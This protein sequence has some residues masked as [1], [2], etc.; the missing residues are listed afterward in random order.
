MRISDPVQAADYDTALAAFGSAAG[1]GVAAVFHAVRA[2][3]YRSGKDRTPLTALRTGRGAC[4]AKHILLRDLLR[5]R[6]LRADVELVECDFAAAVP[7]HP[8]M[9]DALRRAAGAGGVRDVHCWVR[10]HDGA[11]DLCLDATWPD[12][13]APYGFA[14][15]DGWTGRGD[16]RPAVTGGVVR[17]APEDVLTAKAALLAG[18]TAEERRIRL[19]FLAD[20]SAWLERLPSEQQGG[21]Q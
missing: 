3:P 20:L 1:P 15:N 7:P 4:T 16:T 13:V 6:G 14:V 2:M 10:L 9:P 19:A 17:A 8:S 18:F 11:G 21:R 12:A 5:A